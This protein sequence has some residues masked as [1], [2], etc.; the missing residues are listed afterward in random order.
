MLT[1]W[2]TGPQSQNR[3]AVAAKSKSQLV[4]SGSRN[5]KRVDSRARVNNAVPALPLCSDIQPFRPH[6]RLIRKT[7]RESRIS[8]TAEAYWPYHAIQYRPAHRSHRLSCVLAVSLSLPSQPAFPR[9]SPS[10]PP[11]EIQSSRSRGTSSSVALR[12][13]NNTAVN[14]AASNL[15]LNSRVTWH[16]WDKDNAYPLVP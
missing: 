13:H 2:T 15:S 8:R 14:L 3:R 1:T 5:E 16:G 12:L 4:I 6:Q 11:S 10:P 9:P 7:W